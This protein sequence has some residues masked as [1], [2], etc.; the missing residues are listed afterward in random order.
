MK[1][2][3]E[4]N[5]KE[6]LVE[7]L[8]KQGINNPTDIQ[9]LAI[10]KAIEGLS[11]VA[12]S[13]TG[14]GKTLAYLIPVIQKIDTTKNE[15]QAIILAPTHEL[16]AQINSTI[17]ELSKN[18]KNKVS[19]LMIV[20]SGNIKRQMDS[21]K[22]KPQIIVG[23]SGRIME[24]IQ[25]K[26]I[27][28][29]TVKILVMDEGDK[30]LHF[31]NV[32]EVNAI[33]KAM[34]RDTQKLLFSAT[35]TEETLAVVGKVMDNY[36]LIKV[37]EK[38]EVNTDIEHAYFFV[39]SRDKDDALRRIIHATKASKILVFI[40]RNYDLKITLEKLRFHKINVD[41]L[42]GENN[43]ERRKKALDDFRNGKIQVLMA[44]DVAARGLDI[45]GLTHI[46]NLDIP[47]DPKN[48]LHRVGRV[49]RAG[50]KGTAYSIVDK[51][52][53]RIINRYEKTFDIEIPE[54]VTYEGEIITKEERDERVPKRE[55]KV[56]DERVKKVVKAKSK[57]KNSSVAR[58]LSR[59]R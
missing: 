53:E 38:N 7:A 55:K 47:E 12:Q 8:K 25:K 32:E 6:D 41:S 43:K 28:A 33:R 51:S 15:N 2:F 42:H 34:M 36:E 17:I 48:Y 50:A 20:G 22:K 13:E 30:L 3:K 59:R 14:T 49:G 54:M 23:S 1:E 21:L 37:K 19:S 11:L 5:I 56:V 45:K 35:L 10:P 9:A 26:K 24:L 44:S 40:N 29:H 16:A 52:E 4:L 18:L 31:K 46:I 27:S 57:S 58:A 39:Q